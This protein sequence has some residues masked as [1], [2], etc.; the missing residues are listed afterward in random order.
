MKKYIILGLSCTMLLLFSSFATPTI[1]GKNVIAVEGASC[2]VSS[3]GHSVT[4]YRPDGNVRKACR[5][6][7][8]ILRSIR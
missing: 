3:G 4:T 7:R 5:E 6:A 1:N 8:R 2:T